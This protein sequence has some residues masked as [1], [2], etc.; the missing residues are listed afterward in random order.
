MALLS[1]CRWVWTPVHTTLPMEGGPAWRFSRLDP[2][3]ISPL[4]LAAVTVP[5]LTSLLSLHSQ[6]NLESTLHTFHTPHT[7][8][9]DNLESST[10]E[11]FERDVTKYSQYEE[12]VYR[13]LMDRSVPAL[14]PLW[15]GSPL[16]WLSEG[17]H[18]TLLAFA[19]GLNLCYANGSTLSMR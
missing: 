14:S 18:W 11:V 6:D 8:D 17:S 19:R 10:Y 13:A 9:Q 16:T 7:F 1:I 2:S 5:P 15:G 3:I 4:P 12:A